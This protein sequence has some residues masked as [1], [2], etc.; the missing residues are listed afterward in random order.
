MLANERHNKIYKMIQKDGA[1]TTAKLMEL[2]DISIETVRRD[3]LTMEKEGLLKRVHGG[4]VAIAEFKN[5][6]PFDVRKNENIK[7][8]QEVAQKAMQFVKEGDIIGITGGS[9]A[10]LFVEEL[11]KRFSNLTLV[12]FSLDLFDILRDNNSFE[13]ILCGGNLNHS[14]GTFFHGIFVHDILEKIG[15]NKAFV[16]PAAISLASGLCCQSSDYALCVRKMIESAT[17]TYVLSD[18]T[19]FEKKGG[20]RYSEMKKEFTYVTDRAL[21]AELQNLYKENGMK[22]IL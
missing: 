19:K 21:P 20:L 16:F 10:I 22:I 8:K 6:A 9:T 2:F 1:V 18:N 13:V 12:I 3:L 5:I 14:G 15:I 7:L 11:K 4:A 17:K